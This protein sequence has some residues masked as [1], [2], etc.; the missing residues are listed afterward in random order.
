MYYHCIFRFF[1]L[2]S[3]LQLNPF[4]DF[5]ILATEFFSTD[6]SIWFLF[7]SLVSLLRLFYF[8]AKAHHL[9][10]V[11]FVPN[12]FINAHFSILIMTTLRSLSDSSNVSVFLGL[13]FIDCLF[14]ILFEILV[15]CVISNFFQGHQ[16]LWVL[17]CETLDLTWTFCFAWLPLTPPIG[18]SGRLC[19]VTAKLA[20]KSRFPISLHWYTRGCF[21]LLPGRDGSSAPH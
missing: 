21:S 17:C 16:D 15:S 7:L 9:I 19:F 4:I 10:L 3:I 20:M 12:M 14:F 8:F 6:I 18:R 13:V 11:A 2:A 1:P 5:F